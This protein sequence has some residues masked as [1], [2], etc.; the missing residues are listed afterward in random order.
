LRVLQKMGYPTIQQRTIGGS[1]ELEAFKGQLGYRVVLAPDGEVRILKDAQSNDVSNDARDP[2][3]VEAQQ[4][5]QQTQEIEEEAF[6]KKRHR[7]AA[8]Q[9]KKRQALG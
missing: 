1:I 2:L 9:R 7:P 8:S 4:I 6:E 3:V 5:I